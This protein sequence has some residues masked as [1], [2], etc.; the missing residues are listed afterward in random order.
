MR[1]DRIRHHAQLERRAAVA[2]LPAWTLSTRA[3]QAP[4]RRTRSLFGGFP[5]L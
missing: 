4:G 5:L 3:A 1:D 2:E